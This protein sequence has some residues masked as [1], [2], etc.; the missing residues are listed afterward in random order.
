MIRSRLA[1]SKVLSSCVVA[2]FASLSLHCG[3]GGD[4]GGVT[5]PTEPTIALS[6]NTA[7]FAVIAGGPPPAPQTVTISNSGGGTL[8]GLETS[9]SYTAGQASGWLAAA[10]SSTEAPSTLILTATPGSLAPATYT[11]NVA[12]ASAAASNSPQTL[13]VTLTVG[14]GSGGP[15]IALSSASQTFT[16]PAGGTNPAAQTVEVSNAGVGT[17]DGL[18]TSVT[19]TGGQPTG[20]LSAALSSPGA[21]STVTLTATI[22]SLAAGVY[23]ASVAITS[24]SAGN[25]PQT[26][27]VT[28]NV[29][30]AGAGP[31]IALASTTKSFTATAGGDNPERQTIDVSN[32]GGG[33]LNGLAAKVSYGAGQPTG[34]LNASLNRT[35]A[36]ATLTLAA[37][38]G[39]LAA[40][41][42][43]ATVAVTSGV[44]GNSPQNVTVTF[45]VAPPAPTI[46][47]SSPTLTFTT[48]EGGADPAPQTVQVTSGTA[49]ALT[50]LTAAVSY[51]TP[52]PGEWLTVSINPTTAPSTLTATP[53]L[54]GLAAGTYTANVAIASAAAGNTPQTIAVTFF[55]D[56]PDARLLYGVNSSTDALSIYDSRTGAGRIVGPL[57]PNGDSF[58]TPV[59]MAI[60]Q[61]DFAL[62]VWNN[63]LTGSLLTVDPATGHATAISTAQG[64]LLS[65]AFDATGA[66]YG[67]SSALYSIDPSAGVRTVIGSLGSGFRE[68][69]AADFD[70]SGVLLGVELNG[71]G[72]ERLLSINTG[73][74]AATAIATLSQDIG[75]IGSMAFDP[76]GTLVGSGFGGSQGDILFDL[77][78]ATG[79]VSNVR[80]IPREAG[81]APQGMAFRRAC[82]F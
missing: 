74:G 23:T 25:S 69:G 63:S 79:T 75:V 16:A 40:G 4:G 5:P 52:P 35:R 82:T 43:N 3:G 71:S 61:N 21:P 11:A 76:A 46:V 32:G 66:L 59:A 73:T 22:G 77:D 36:P 27:A 65:I 38:T 44:A 28:F 7:T 39:T 60:R 62:F 37:T 64:T 81:G 14:T 55:V 56:P 34:W 20:W 54:S 48:S 18:A 1:S 13:A 72:P 41:T 9:I 30:Q 53:H 31:L 15:I 50:G 51:P 6:T 45:T 24:P 10:L 29:A 80:P 68:V 67:V 2:A 57:D 26:I 47:L 70:C 58:D 42:Y 78:P 19:Y 12:I 33:T 49:G 17:L 8:D